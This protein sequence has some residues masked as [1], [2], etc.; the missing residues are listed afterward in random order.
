MVEIPWYPV[1]EELSEGLKHCWVVGTS[2]AR[3][4]FG[5]GRANGGIFF[6][7]A[8]PGATS[9]HAVTTIPRAVWEHPTPPWWKAYFWRWCVPRAVR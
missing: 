8:L 3:D 6:V 1:P 7:L 4:D 9:P 5:V 2:I